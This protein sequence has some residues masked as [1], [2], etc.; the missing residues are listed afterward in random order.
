[1]KLK[2]IIIMILI[3]LTFTTGCTKYLSDNNNKR[4]TNESTGQSL[5]S[6]ILCKPTEKELITIYKKY[7]KRIKRIQRKLSRQVNGSNNYQKTKIKISKLY[8]CI[9]RFFISSLQFPK[10]FSTISP[11]NFSIANLK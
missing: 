6:N 1:M 3:I 4:I 7:E 11:K 2:K 9:L 5:T 8:S 10:F